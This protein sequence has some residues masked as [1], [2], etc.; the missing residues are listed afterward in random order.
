[1][2]SCQ[3]RGHQTAVLIRDTPHVAPTV[4]AITRV[5]A[6]LMAGWEKVGTYQVEES[7]GLVQRG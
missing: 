4:K 3:W 7:E 1:M 2:S 5:L 6:V